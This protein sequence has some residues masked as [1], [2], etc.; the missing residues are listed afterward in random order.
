M[1]DSTYVQTWDVLRN[2]AWTIYQDYRELVGPNAEKLLDH[3][4]DLKNSARLLDAPNA[5]AVI[6]AL[7]SYRATRVGAILGVRGMFDGA[8]IQMG[9]VINEPES[10]PDAILK[11]LDT[12][13]RA[14]SPIDTVTSIGGSFGAPVAAGTNVG[15]GV[16]VRVTVDRNNRP[17]ET[18][19]VTEIMTAECEID[20]QGGVLP[21]QEVFTV[22]GYGLGPDIVEIEGSGLD[23]Q[24]RVDSADT[25]LLQNS[26]FADV[27]GSAG[28]PASIPGWEISV[29]SAGRFRL[30]TTVHRTN[31]IEATAYSLRF[32]SGTTN[33]VRQKIRS[34]GATVT[35]A[36]EEPWDFS[37]W[38]N[39]IGASGAG[40]LTIG[41]GSRTRS[42]AVASGATGWTRATV[43]E[44]TPQNRYYPNWQQAD[45]YASI[46]WSGAAPMLVDNAYL[47]PMR[48][49]GGTWTNIFAGST[50]FLRGDE[51]TINDRR[52]S[53]GAQGVL[54]WAF[55]L[56]YGRTL[57]N[58][59]TSPTIADPT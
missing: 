59:S 46:R 18:G 40:T 55:D 56:L 28:A 11:K 53:A 16:M 49:L 21:G 13:M 41:L 2:A 35:D 48:P 31:A 8:L 45:A 47:G 26:S 6:S 4:D 58:T 37:L 42:I 33:T 20:M 3:E 43:F 54:Q 19:R 57:P 25:S 5:A 30:S 32:N 15:N 14:Q 34:A 17:L 27:D 12:Y 52:N 1:P 22:E 24:L 51:F 39:K 29:G 23:G 36:D 7:A 38:Y 50:D 10:T 44:T 9:R